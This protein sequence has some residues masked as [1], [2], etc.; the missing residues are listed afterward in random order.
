MT[1]LESGRIVP[2]V[3]RFIIGPTAVS[4]VVERIRAEGRLDPTSISGVIAAF[5][6]IPSEADVD[7]AKWY[8]RWTTPKSRSEPGQ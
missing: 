2:G 4:N 7:F 1:S 5:A 6:V 8:V 3:H